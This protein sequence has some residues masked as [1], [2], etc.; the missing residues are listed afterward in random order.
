MIIK[1]VFFLIHNYNNKLDNSP[2]ELNKCNEICLWLLT[3]KMWFSNTSS[4]FLFS[5]S[6]ARHILMNS[7]VCGWWLLMQIIFMTPLCNTLQGLHKEI[8]QNDKKG[9][10]NIHPLALNLIE[11]SS[12]FN[13]VSD[14]IV[15][16][17]RKDWARSQKSKARVMLYLDT[18]TLHRGLLWNVN[19]IFL[20]CYVLIC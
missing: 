5:V 19:E 14:N 15:S 10:W 6:S 8:F 18:T 4:L 2:C 20:I 9:S 11:E 12:D 13:A 17:P 3:E 7:A 16:G 1:K